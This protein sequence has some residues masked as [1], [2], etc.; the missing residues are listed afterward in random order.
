MFSMADTDD[1]YLMF[2]GSLCA[3]VTGNPLTVLV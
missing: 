3:I 2:F 1:Y